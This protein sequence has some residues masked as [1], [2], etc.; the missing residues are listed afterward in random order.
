MFTTVSPITWPGAGHGPLWLGYSP[1]SIALVA[2]LHDVCKIGCYKPS[3]RNVKG[4]GG[5]WTQVPTFTYE[6]P[7][8]YGHGEKS[9]YVI[10]GFVRLTREEAM[11]IRWHMGFS[12]TEDSRLVGR[13]FAKYPLAF[14]LS[15]ADMEATYFRGGAVGQTR[16]MPP[17]VGR[18]SAV[19]FPPPAGRRSSARQSAALTVTTALSGGGRAQERKQFIL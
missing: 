16:C 13:A 6:D 3:T 10:N 2:L 17:V 4:E 19:M 12:G 18:H 14:A 1:E 7:L 11:A 5:K 8:P 15:V 9:V